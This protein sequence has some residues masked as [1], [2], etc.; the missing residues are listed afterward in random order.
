LLRI[1]S[2]S[3]LRR[4]QTYLFSLAMTAQLDPSTVKIN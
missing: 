3:A 2:S 4:Q 1:R